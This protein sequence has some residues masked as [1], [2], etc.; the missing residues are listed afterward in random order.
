[1]PEGS[2]S[3]DPAS[4]PRDALRF[5]IGDTGPTSFVLGDDELDYLIANT[6]STLLAA[7]EAAE[8]VAAYYGRMRDKTVGNLSIS[9]ARQGADYRTL[10]DRLRL[11]AGVQVGVKTLSAP[12]AGGLGPT[13]LG[14]TDQGR[15]I[16]DLIPLFSG[17]GS[18]AEDGNDL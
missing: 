13:Y 14:G 7:I 9:Y 8:R 10:A 4:D 1:M 5:L 2:Y 17:N 3:G 6:S 16:E 15:T 18:D 12:V 11:Q